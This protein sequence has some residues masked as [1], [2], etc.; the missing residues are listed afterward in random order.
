MLRS[1]DLGTEGSQPGLVEQEDSTRAE[2]GPNS[3][4]VPRLVALPPYGEV[5]RYM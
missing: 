5:A 3:M 2:L 4:S 1:G